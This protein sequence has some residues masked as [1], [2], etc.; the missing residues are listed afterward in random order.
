MDDDA[1][2]DRTV[3][4]AFVAIGCVFLSL[5]GFLLVWLG[6]VAAESDGPVGGA[7]IAILIAAGFGLFF[8]VSGLKGTVE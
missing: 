5:A 3:R 2:L 4:I 1:D 7:A 6:P 8:V